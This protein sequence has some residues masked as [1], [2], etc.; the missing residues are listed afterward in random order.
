MTAA[1]RTTS[2]HTA[3]VALGFDAIV[4]AWYD[5]LLEQAYQEAGKRIARVV[6]GLDVAYATQGEDII[7]IKLYGDIEQPDSLVVTRRDMMRVEGQLARRLE[8]VRPYVRLRPILFVGW[9]PGDEGLARLYTA[10]TQSLGEHK[11]RN[12]IVWPDPC[13]EDVAWWADD[14][15][16]IIPAEPLPFLRALQQ[17]VQQQRVV[18]TGYR[19]GDVVRKPPYKFLNYFDPDDRNIF[20]GREVESPLVYRLTLS[21]PLLTLFGR[22]G[23]GKTSLLRAGVVPLLLNEGYT[24]AYVRALGDP[25]QAIR[26]G[27]TRALSL[28][29]TGGKAGEGGEGLRDFFTHTLAPETRL[30]VILDQFEELFIRSSGPTRRQF[31]RELGD[32]LGLEAPEVRFIL[33][34]REDFLAQLDEARRAPQA[35]EAAPIPYVLRNSYRLTSLAQDTA[36]LAIVEPASRAQ[37]QVEPQLV[38]ALLGRAADVETLSPASAP[39]GSL[40]EADGSV[41]APSLQIVMDRLYRMALHEAGHHPPPPEATDWTPPPLTLTLARYREAGGAG[42]ILGEYVTGALDRVPERGGDRLLAEAL[43]KVLVTGQE[44]KAALSDAELLRGVA[45]TARAFDP[46]DARDVACL[47]DTRAVLVDLRL[48]RSFQ[49][50]AHALYELAHDHMA[51][52]IATWIDEAEMQAKLARELLRRELASWQSLHKLIEPASLRLLYAQRADLRRLS[53]EELEL[54]LRSALAGNHEGCPYW[55]ERAR[56]A[57]VDVDAIAREGL[58]SDNFRARAAAVTALG[59]VLQAQTSEVLE[60]SEVWAALTAM[61]ADDYPQVRVA[62]IAALEALRPDGAWRMHLKYEC[63]VPAGKFLMGDDNGDSDEKPAH[64]VH[65][66]AYYTGKYPVT[67]AE[68]ARYKEDIKQPFTIPQGKDN[69]PVVEVSWYDARDYAAWAGMRLLT[70]AEWEKAALWEG[71]RG[72]VGE[73]GMVD[74]LVGAISRSR[75]GS[76]KR[77]YPWG[78]EFDQ[79]KC[80]IS[81]FGI[82]TTTPVGKYSPQGDSPYGCADMAGN[83]WEWTSSLK[84]NYPYRADDGR[85]DMTSSGGRVLRGGSFGNDGSAARC[86][87]RHGPDP[88]VRNVNNGL[89]CGV[90]VSPG[91]ELLDF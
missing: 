49:V 34:L 9:N 91:S 25:R 90:G 53:A 88:S 31:W 54:L 3:I 85:E 66:A 46:D 44:T 67:N 29:L 42:R 57:G 64:E 24:Y 45:E 58:Q 15:V 36:R 43:L 1:R 87:Y 52:E 19:P 10:A 33:C 79:A 75:S 6:Q 14:N 89:R 51:A 5:G 73:R 74:R 83:V 84:E 60:T 4:S 23:V 20:C 56:A 71:E 18:G 82:G 2:V 17:R 72:R 12:Y 39:L 47:R 32:C 37:C 41:P 7:L 77:K 26:E 27:V 63:Y 59:Q 50:G 70:E 13:P 40:V 21:Y 28:P 65:L 80:N 16:E 61:L 8:D 62:A 38:D 55:F 69:H 30:V 48:V 78:D 35:G 11:R 22:S 86:A 76:K 68:Y 81:E